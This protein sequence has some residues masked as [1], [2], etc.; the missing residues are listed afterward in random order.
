MT[1]PVVARL[2]RKPLTA[3]RAG[4]AIA[5]ITL[6]ITLAGGALMTVADRNDFPNLGRGLWWAVQTVTTVGYGDVT[7]RTTTGRVLGTVV[8]AAGIGFV[9]VLTAAITATFVEETRRRLGTRD[10]RV[11]DALGEMTDRLERLERRLDERP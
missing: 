6:A 8:M 4:T 7:P 3:R 2:Q 1:G 11:A 10:D 9:T 5:V